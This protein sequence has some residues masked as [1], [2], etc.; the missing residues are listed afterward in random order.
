MTAG[1][2]ATA[3]L[4]ACL[5]SGAAAALLAPGGP[6]TRLAR[7]RSRRAPAAV[8]LLLVCASVL[9]V[10]EPGLLVL[11]GIGAAVGG[12]VVRLVRRQRAD[13]AAASVRGKV[14]ALCDAV[15]AELA[16][17]QTGPDA[18]VR[19]VDEWPLLLP[20]ARSARTGGDVAAALREV[21]VVPGAADLR[22]VGAAWQVAHHT[23]HGL[24]DTLAR[25]AAGLRETERT[26]R[27]VS[28]E[29]ASA[30]ATARLVAGLPVAALVLGSGAGADPWAFLL[31]SPA[32]LACLGGG[33]GCALGGLSWIEAL[34]RDVERG[35]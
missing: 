6:R 13:R 3:A 12:A 14:I 10:G 17:G 23:G 4:V 26:R 33:L 15:Q 32:G 27:V 28:G 2:A 24:A 19:A 16:A 30:R 25:V 22:V 8:M 29:L 21:A 34:A 9:V 11:G 1:P 31:A 18:L 7:P 35:R 20:V 5:L